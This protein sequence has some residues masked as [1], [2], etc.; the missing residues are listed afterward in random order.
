ME[1]LVITTIILAVWHYMYEGMIA[2]TLR[3]KYKHKLFELRDELH[4]VKLI[5]K[6]NKK[7]LFIIEDGINHMIDRMDT[8]TLSSIW[9][10]KK[11]Y[12]NI[13]E[14]KQ[15]IEILRS[16]INQCDNSS[17]KGI[18][19]RLN[20]I[21]R[22]ILRVNS[23]GLTLYLIPIYIGFYIIATFISSVYEWMKNMKDLLVYGVTDY[24]F[25]PKDSL[26]H[27]QDGNS[28]HSIA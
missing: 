13:P 27:P 5:D 11:I 1:Y 10:A 28:N 14:V 8:L 6:E 18:D 7:V 26:I 23:G 20:K 2:P 12:E 9:K 15:E 17:L 4:E 24:A 3:L 21:G 19:K 16:A 25:I 22:K